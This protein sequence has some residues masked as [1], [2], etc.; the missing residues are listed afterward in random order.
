MPFLIK[1]TKEMLET[2]KKNFLKTNSLFHF[3]W[4]I[5]LQ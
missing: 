2:E 5:F 4:V 1:Q 3:E